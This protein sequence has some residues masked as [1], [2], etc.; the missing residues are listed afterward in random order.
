M[1]K[2]YICRET[3]VDMDAIRKRFENK[4][5]EELDAEFEEFKRKKLAE[6]NNKPNKPSN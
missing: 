6:K 2:D 5:V 3:G 4:T 1:D